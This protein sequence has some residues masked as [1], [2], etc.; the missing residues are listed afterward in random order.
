ML[1]VDTSQHGWP[2][3]FADETWRLHAGYSRDHTLGRPLQALVAPAAPGVPP[4]RWDALAADVA[5]GAR[6]VLHGL[7][8]VMPGSEG[9]PGQR[10]H[11]CVGASGGCE[12]VEHWSTSGGHAPCEVDSGLGGAAMVNRLTGLPSRG[13]AP[14]DLEEEHEEHRITHSVS[15]EAT[16][17]STTRP[18]TTDHCS[19][20]AGA[21]SWLCI[22]APEDSLR[23]AVRTPGTG[24]SQGTPRACESAAPDSPTAPTGQDLTCCATDVLLEKVVASEAGARAFQR[25]S[26]MGTSAAAGI[27]LTHH[28]SGSCALNLGSAHGLHQPALTSQSGWAPEWNGGGAALALAPGGVSG[29]TFDLSF[30]WGLR[31]QRCESSSHT[32]HCSVCSALHAG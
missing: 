22:S 28:A 5:A 29:C 1:L 24:H 25:A 21:S 23:Q 13:A 2:V 32:R 15:L 16:A 17:S 20:Q 7:R 3:V 27:L 19:S 30:R 8:A 4:P 11:A 31:C 26:A 6:F 9:E 18:S 12:V 10:G 14:R